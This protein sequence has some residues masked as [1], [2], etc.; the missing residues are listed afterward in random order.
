MADVTV[1][2]LAK[3]VGA[4]VERLLSQMGQAGLVHK[5]ATDMVSD[6]EKQTLLAFLKT[7][8]GESAEAPRKI[9]L[10]RKTTTTL[11]T[12][13]GSARKTINVEVRKKRTYVKR[14]DIEGDVSGDHELGQDADELLEIEADQDIE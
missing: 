1:N 8:H 3:S 13:T 5:N 4:S 11:K 12:G 10:K 6:D 7:A 9:T 2:D 14:A